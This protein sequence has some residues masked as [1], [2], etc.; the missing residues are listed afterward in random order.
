MSIDMYP[1][2]SEGLNK[3][4]EDAIYFFTTAFEPFSNYSAHQVEIWGKIFPTAEHAY[5]WH[6]FSASNPDVAAQ[7]LAAGSPEAA[8][9]IATAHKSSVRSEWYARRVVIMEEI[10]IAKAAQHEDVREMLQKSGRRQIV[11]NNPVDAFW[12]AGPEGNGEN[13]IG[14][15]WMKIRDT[16]I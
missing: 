15:I 8:K 1:A 9:R 14:R 5:Q 4:T 2:S 7:I 11:E 3:E 13:W 12:G 10:L 16:M 6:K